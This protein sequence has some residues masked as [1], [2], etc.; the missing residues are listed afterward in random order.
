MTYQH[1]L[2]P[3]T[4]ARSEYEYAVEKDA[5]LQMDPELATAEGKAGPLK[6]AIYFAIMAFALLVVFYGMINQRDETV[7]RNAPA[8]AEQSAPPQAPPATGAPQAAQFNPQQGTQGG[9][10]PP[11]NQPQAQPQQNPPAQPK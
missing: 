11:A 10:N 4:R 3:V 2:T 9:P 5:T 6:I 7:E 8:T 1:S